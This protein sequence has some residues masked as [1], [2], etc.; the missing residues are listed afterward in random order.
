MD[1]NL[2]KNMLYACIGE[3]NEERRWKKLMVKSDSRVE[4]PVLKSRGS[5]LPMTPDP[6]DLMP[7][8]ILNRG[9]CTHRKHRQ[10]H[11]HINKNKQKLKK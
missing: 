8:F 1:V 7:S 11:I 3:T 10:T 9:P 2:I 5:Q 6:G 4:I